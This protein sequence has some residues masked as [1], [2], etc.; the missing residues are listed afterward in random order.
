MKIINI[1]K[2]LIIL[3]KSLF[4][5]RPLPLRNELSGSFCPLFLDLSLKRRLLKEKREISSDLAKKRFSR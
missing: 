4:D 2:I 5:R 1:Q 3:T